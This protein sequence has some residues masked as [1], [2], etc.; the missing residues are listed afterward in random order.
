MKVNN[1]LM[2]QSYLLT[3]ARY[4]FSVYEKRILYRLVELCQCALEGQKLNPNFRINNL[5]FDELREVEM[6]I[7][8]FLKDEKDENYSIAK[9]AL[10]DLK[11]KVIEYEDSEVWK[12]ISIIEMPK[13]IK[14]GYVKFILQKEIYEA[15]LNFSKGFRK[16][17]L[18]TAME[19]ESVYA[20]R[21]YELLSGKEGETITYSVNN[22]K[23]MFQLENKY[24][25]TKDFIRRVIEPAQKELLKKAPFSFNYK[26]VKEFGSKKIS[27]IT[28]YPYEIVAN[29]DNDLERKTLQKETALSWDLDKMVIDY[30]KQNYLFDTDEIKHNRDLFVEAAEKIDIMNFLS[31][32]RRVAS[33]KKN[34]K[35]WIIGAL[36]KEVAAKR[37]A[38]T[39]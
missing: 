13:L 3:T 1:K 14:N 4:N 29:I 6:P 33:S 36:K 9:K 26:T 38:E 11:N 34:P 21:F 22:L 15:L 39:T 12:P 8:A 20:M 27:A 18:K 35:G 7:S 10:W 37:E 23:I 31:K 24:K 2:I 30:L 32:K 19:F 28:F 17:E 25:E 5:L 16:Y